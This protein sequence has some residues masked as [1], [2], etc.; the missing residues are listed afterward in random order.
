MVHEVFIIIEPSYVAGKMWLESH[1][2]ML[3]LV[4]DK[5][6][7]HNIQWETKI[8]YTILTRDKYILHNINI[9]EDMVGN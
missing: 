1:F 8:S 3:A 6:P 2:L 9:D 4:R 7:P 5:Y